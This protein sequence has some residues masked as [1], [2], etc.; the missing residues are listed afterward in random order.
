MLKTVVQIVFNHLP[1]ESLIAFMAMLVAV[2]TAGVLWMYRKSPEVKYLIAIEFFAAIWALGSGLEYISKSLELKIFWSQLTYL[3]ISFLPVCYYLFTTA[4]SQKFHLIIPRNVTL[5]SIIPFIT[6]PLV[7]TNPYHHLVWENVGPTVSEHNTLIISHGPWFWIFWSYSIT[8]IFAGLYNLF[9][10]IYK[11]TAYYRSQVSTLL[12]ATL[13]PFGGNL[14]Y[15]TGLNPI[16]GFDWTPVLFVFTGLVITSGIIK[17]RMFDLVPFVRNSLIDT[18][19][20]GVIIV[21]AEGFVEDYNPAV[22]KIFNLKTSVIRNRFTDAFT[23]Y[24]NLLSLKDSEENR[25]IEIEA[26]TPDAPRIYQ[27]RITPIYNHNGQFSG[28]LLQLNDVTFLKN[29]EKQ[30]RK[31]NKQLEAEVEERGRLIED[32]DAFAHTVAHDL[33][34]SLGSVYNTAEVIEDCIKTGNTEALNEFSGYIKTSAGKAMHITHE[35]LLLATVNHHQ[36][37]KKPLDMGYI[38]K[39][40]VGQIKDLIFDSKAHISFPDKWPSALG[41]A[42]WI[43]EVWVNYLSNAIKYGGKP[44]KIV[45]G[46]ETEKHYIRFWIKDN[47][48][49]IAPADQDKLFKKYSRL[50]PDEA[51]GYGLGL[52][53]VK[54]IVRKMDGYVGVDSTG[55][56]GEGACFWFCLPLVHANEPEK[57]I[58][59]NIG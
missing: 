26:G 29:T 13:I 33:R 7:F 9:Q 20:D 52:S 56:K 55:E 50:K 54:R 42:P 47:G 4:F 27:V 11:F 58:K 39:N 35:L 12:I 51:E 31:V 10:S 59:Q 32:L 24:E 43:E 8:L 41:Y 48:N 5:L 1:M 45:A 14:V 44:P 37:D 40:A 2:G 18:M 30:L 17:Y 34:N 49:G 6:I 36:V 22:N 16:P 46:A 3:G 53:I 57:K 21:N 38:V 23:S 15:V 25:L 19:S 28:N